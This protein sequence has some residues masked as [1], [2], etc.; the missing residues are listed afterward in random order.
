MRT[1]TLAKQELEWLC[2]SEGQKLKDKK[3]ISKDWTGFL[4]L[5]QSMLNV[6][7]VLNEQKEFIVGYAQDFLENQLMPLMM[8]NLKDLKQHAILGKLVEP[9]LMLIASGRPLEG[10]YIKV[11]SFDPTLY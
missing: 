11:E 1:V 2:Q 5:S 6:Y 8:E 9:L 10:D 4:G 3:D 7:N